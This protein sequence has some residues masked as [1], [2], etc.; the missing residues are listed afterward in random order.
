MI[1]NIRLRF[2]PC[3][4]LILFLWVWPWLLIIAQTNSNWRYLY[5]FL[6][7]LLLLVNLLKL[8]ARDFL[9]RL[10]L[11]LK[12]IYNWHLLINDLLRAVISS[13]FAIFID[14]D[15]LVKHNISLLRWEHLRI[16]IVNNLN[17]LIVKFI[18]ILSEWRFNVTIIM[19]FMGWISLMNNNRIKLILMVLL[20]NSCII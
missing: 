17:R 12:Q 20:E 9:Y 10:K 13:I 14:F 11:L 8:I 16:N 7:L 2:L 4:L 6:L 15:F 3:C 1:N 18:P 19:P 5:F